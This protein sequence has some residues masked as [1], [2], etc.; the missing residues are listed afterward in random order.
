V[1]LPARPAPVAPARLADSIAA[2]SLTLLRT[3]G[4]PLPLPLCAAPA[5]PVA[6]LSYVSVLVPGGA[7]VALDA[8]LAA[9][10]V[11]VRRR[12]VSP[13][14][15]GRVVDSLLGAGGDAPV[16]VS[17]YRQAIP[18][19]GAVGLPWGMAGQLERLAQR[20]PLVL[21]SFG[22]PYV[23]AGVPSAGAVV[24]AWSGIPAVQRAVA[25]ALAGGASIDGRLPVSVPPQW[26]AGD[27]ER[28]PAPRTGCGGAR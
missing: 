2:R 22:D 8:E 5:A 15:I 3:G 10:G 21:V 20:R 6:S 19:A 25:R 26:R 11:A 1:P 13:E 14:G 4:R 16:L 23:A 28:Y 17:I 24:Q 12:P 7:N 9:R 18:W 27:G